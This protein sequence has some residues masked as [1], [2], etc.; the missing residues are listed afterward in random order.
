MT[1]LSSS[2]DPWTLRDRRKREARHSCRPGRHVNS[3]R[4]AH[5]LPDRQGRNQTPHSRTCVGPRNVHEKFPEGVRPPPLRVKEKGLSMRERRVLAQL[6]CNAKC[7]LLKYYQHA[8]RAAPNDICLRPLTHRP[9][10][11]D[12]QLRGRRPAPRPSDDLIS[13]LWTD[14]GRWLSI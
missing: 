1:N 12:D 10:L 9:G 8:I 5:R 13:D 4:R 14:P 6:L 3:R 11:H 7:P 2:I